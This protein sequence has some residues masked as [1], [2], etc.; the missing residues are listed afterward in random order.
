MFLRHSK[1]IFPST[2]SFGGC[3]LSSIR[4][5]AN[6]QQHGGAGSGRNI[7]LEGE[8]SMDRDGLPVSGLVQRDKF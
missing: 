5:M 1:F 8:R 6:E 2:S 4:S 7:I 3:T